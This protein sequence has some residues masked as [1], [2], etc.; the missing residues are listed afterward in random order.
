VPETP[1]LVPPL[2]R[3]LYLKRIP[4]LSGLPTAEVAVLAD[5]AGERFFPKGS[6]VFREEQ[7]VGSMHFVVQGSLAVLRRGARV[8]EVQPGG[9]IGGLHVFTRDALG[10]HVVAEDDT[11]TLEVDVDAMADVLED[12]F[13]IL[14]HVLRETS[15]QALELLVRF[16][17]D[18]S[19]AFEHTPPAPDDPADSDLVGKLFFLR[20]MAVFERSSVTAL[21]ELARTMAQ[22]RF[23]TG[24]VLWQEGEPSPGL[25]LIR[26]GSVRAT[27]SGGVSFQAGPGAPL[28]AL[29]GVAEVPRWYEAVAETPV[30]ALQ[31]QAGVLVDLFE[32]NFEMAMDY[33]AVIARATQRVLDWSAAGSA[34][35]ARGRVD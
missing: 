25:L 17:L 24:T 28:G 20:R 32:D 27:G 29:E 13:P 26:S 9:E 6:V 21:A 3:M 2:E 33:L 15:R 11:L 12:R 19:V 22:V 1:R 14:Q 18:P 16:Q 34:L 8:G 30:L 35:Q 23:E 10:S 31:G 7:A 4:M 5:A